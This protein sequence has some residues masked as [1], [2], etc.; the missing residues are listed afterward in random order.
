MEE[1]D[2]FLVILQFWLEFRP[3][4]RLLKEAVQKFLKSLNVSIISICGSFTK[5]P[6]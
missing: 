1:F 5:Q 3:D 2:S 6:I 4:D